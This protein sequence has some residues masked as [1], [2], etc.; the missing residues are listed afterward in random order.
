MPF[1]DIGRM[2]GVWVGGILCKRDQEPHVFL[3]I[4]DKNGTSKLNKLAIFDQKWNFWNL[5]A[6][7]DKQP[8]LDDNI[9]TFVKAQRSGMEIIYFIAKKRIKKNTLKKSVNKKIYVDIEKIKIKKILDSAS[10][11]QHVTRASRLKH[12]L[13]ENQINYLVKNL[14]CC[15]NRGQGK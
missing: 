1:I 9:I 10:R 6:N 12:V 15:L 14:L 5:V 3:Y 8:R 13:R 2:V 11:S 4:S 7:F